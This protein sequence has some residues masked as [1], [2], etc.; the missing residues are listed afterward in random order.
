MAKERAIELQLIKPVIPGSS[1]AKGKIFLRHL[2]KEYFTSLNVGFFDP[3]CSDPATCGPISETTGNGIVCNPDGLFVDTDAIVADVETFYTADGQLE[4]DR[5]VDANGNSIFFENIS[6][7]T[8]SANSGGN[9]EVLRLQQDIYKFGDVSGDLAVGI[10]LNIDGVNR[11]A[12]LGDVA[13]IGNG[14]HLLVDDDLERIVLMGSNNEALIAETSTSQITLPNL[15]GTG[16]RLVT[17]DPNGVLSVAI[18][19]LWASAVLDF[20]STNTGLSA[21]LTINV[22]GAAVG[23]VVSLGVP[24]GSVLANS[25]YTAWISAANTATVRFN[26]YS[27]GALDPASGLFKVVVHKF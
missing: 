3:C 2:L 17:A 19:I 16:T 13:G 23:D 18:P 4:D 10:G 20:P 21:D 8:V 15:A 25:N 1:G 11:F 22:T 27:A 14:T 24:A 26:N 6:A 5:T 9:S 7:F 12:D